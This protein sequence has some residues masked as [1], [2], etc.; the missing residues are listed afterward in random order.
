MGDTL[1]LKKVVTRLISISL[2]RMIITLERLNDC[3]K[4]CDNDCRATNIL[5]H[6]IY[7][8]RHN[9]LHIIGYVIHQK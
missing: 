3:S 9:L 2:Y 4:W 8:V 1:T 7:S 6:T 5:Q